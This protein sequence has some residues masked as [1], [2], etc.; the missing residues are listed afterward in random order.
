MTAGAGPCDGGSTARFP[1]PAGAQMFPLEVPQTLVTQENQGLTRR[2]R[3]ARLRDLCELVRG[4]NWMQGTSRRFMGL[5]ESLTSALKLNRLRSEVTRC[6]ELAVTSWGDA[7]SDLDA[8]AALQKLLRGRGIY[9]ADSSSPLAAFSDE[10]LSVPESVAGSPCVTEV[11]P[12]PAMFYLG[13][14]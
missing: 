14:F 5:Q 4:L 11:L 1:P 10:R 12:A 9:G 6:A 8:Q 13:P 3:R 2:V 7:P